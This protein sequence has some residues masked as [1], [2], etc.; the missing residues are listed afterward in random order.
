MRSWSAPDVPRLPGEG[1]PVRLHDTVTGQLLPAATGPVAGLYVCGIT[2]YDATHL[3]HAAT[4]LT[5]DLLHRAWLDAGLQ[6]RFVENV[7]DVDDPLL[8]RARRDGV[9]WTALAADQTDLF[10]EDMAALRVLPP[11]AFDGVSETVDAIAELVGL[12]LTTGAAYRLDGEVYLDVAAAPHFG[13][14][15]SLSEQEMSGL[16]AEH[17]GDPGRQGKRHPGDSLLWRAEREGEPAWGTPLGRG[18]PGWHVECA[19]IAGRHLGDTYDVLAGGADLAYPHH[20][21]SVATASAATGTWPVARRVS[22]VSLVAY[23]GHKMSKSRGNL[24]LVHRLR[25]QAEPAAVRAAVLAHRYREPWEWT[26]DELPATAARLARWREALD[27]PV[28]PGSTA[29]GGATVRAQLRDAL[30]DD[31]DAPR[32]LRELDRWAERTRLQGARDATTGDDVADAADALLGLA[33][34]R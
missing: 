8:E 22:H 20:E 33:L 2:P 31:L 10:R 5:Y 9:D 11:V 26:D 6:V 1:L 25:E 15:T 18:R 34:R 7:T 17:G 12:L 23:D 13:A 3:G 14:L 29:P 32:A 16:D 21:H 28:R 30:A 4:Y 27:A 24:V 19:V